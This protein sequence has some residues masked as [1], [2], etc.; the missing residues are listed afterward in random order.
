MSNVEVYYDENGNP[1]PNP[2]YQS[3]ITS[4]AQSVL[5]TSNGSLV[6]VKDGDT[7]YRVFV[8]DEIV[9]SGDIVTVNGKKCRVK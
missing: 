5:T 8:K 4:Q 3:S 9:K 7:T 1:K 2:S 6:E